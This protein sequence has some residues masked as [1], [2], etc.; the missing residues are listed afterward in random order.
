ML[1]CVCGCGL[2]FVGVCWGRAVEGLRGRILG[3]ADGQGCVVRDWAL[4]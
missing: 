4:V 2:G 1:L 3:G